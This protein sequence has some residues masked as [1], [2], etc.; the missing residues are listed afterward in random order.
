MMLGITETDDGTLSIIVDN[1]PIMVPKDH[2][3]YAALRKAAYAGDADTVRKLADIPVAIREYTQGQVTIQG[4]KVTYAGRELHTSFTD[5]ILRMMA[6]GHEITPLVRFLDNLMQNPSYRAVRELFRFLA[7]HG[8]PITSD[9]GCFLGYKRIRQDW[10]DQHTGLVDNHIGR[11]VEMP[12]NEVDDNWGIDCSDGFHVGSMSYVNTF[13]QGGRIIIVK[14]NPRDVVTVP[15]SETNKLRTCRYEVVAEY[16]GFMG[17]SSVYDA[18]TVRPIT[19]P[20]PALP[21]VALPPDD[22]EVKAVDDGATYTV[23]YARLDPDDP[24]TVQEADTFDDYGDRHEALQYAHDQAVEFIDENGDLFDG[25]DTAP[26]V[27]E[28]KRNGGSLAGY[29][30]VTGPAGARKVWARWTIVKEE[31]DED[32]DEDEDKD[33]DDEDKEDEDE[34]ISFGCLVQECPRCHADL[35]EDNAIDLILEIAGQRITTQTRVDATG[36]VE[37]TPDDAIAEDHGVGIACGACTLD[38]APWLQQYEGNDLVD[39]PESLD[40]L[41]DVDIPPLPSAPVAAPA[42][43]ALAPAGTRLRDKIRALLHRR[44]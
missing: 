1:R 40:E 26:E 5:R 12:R 18:Q 9:D 3:N 36:E 20:R 14:V 2:P 25:A 22:P 24:G 43:T 30:V 13:G 29:A 41:G 15:E 42:T 44:P 16:Q 4:N 37:D 23:V 7:R 35:T 8:I 19:P 10:T 28:F 38:L 21:P 34:T 6:E 39:G 17:E 27:V 32:E 33:E 31:E 11:V